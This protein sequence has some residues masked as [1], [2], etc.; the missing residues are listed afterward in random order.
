MKTPAIFHSLRTFLDACREANKRM[1]IC[2]AD[3]SGHTIMI[4]RETD[5]W[6]GSLEIAQS[7]A[8]TVIAFSGPT[9]DQALTTEKIATMTQPGQPLYGLQNTNQGKVVIFGG[10]IPIYIKGKLHGSIGVSGSTVEDDINLAQVA[11]AAYI[12]AFDEV[13]VDEAKSDKTE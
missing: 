3:R 1:V 4:W 5:A 8:W 9:E 13:P 2:Y 7:K 6:L 12:E 10:G 11:V